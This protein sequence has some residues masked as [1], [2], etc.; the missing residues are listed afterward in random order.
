MAFKMKGFSPFKQKTDTEDKTKTRLESEHEDTWI[1]P[2]DDVNDRIDDIQERISF[3][4]TDIENNDGKTTPTQ[5][6]DLSTLDQKLREL[7][8]KKKDN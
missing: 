8:K 1:N 3:I 7:K 2:S 4:E 5:R 6:V